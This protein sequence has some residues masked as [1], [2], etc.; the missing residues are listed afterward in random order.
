[1]GVAEQLADDQAAAR[2]QDPADLPQGGGAVGDLAEHGGED[3]RVHRAVVVGQGGGVALGRDDV[4]EAA[5]RGAAHH[6]VEEVLLEV[7]DLDRARGP[8]AVR[9]SPP[10]RAATHSAISSV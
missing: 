9:P 3:D 2:L 5:L 10:R 7:E 6:V 8:R 1:M 4:G